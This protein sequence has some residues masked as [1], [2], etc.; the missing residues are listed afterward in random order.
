MDGLL[1]ILSRTDPATILT[2]LALGGGLYRRI[3]DVRERMARIEPKV[4]MLL[5]GHK[6]VNDASRITP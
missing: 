6:V 3:E 4:D 2:L 1:S 5:A